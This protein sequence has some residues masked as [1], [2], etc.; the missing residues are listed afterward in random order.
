MIFNMV[1]SNVVRPV[2]V[3]LP[4]QPTTQPKQNPPPQPKK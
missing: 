3:G 1:I 4:T 2:V